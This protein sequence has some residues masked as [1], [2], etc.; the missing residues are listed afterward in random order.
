MSRKDWDIIFIFLTDLQ[1]YIKKRI[2]LLVVYRSNDSMNIGERKKVDL[3][4]SWLLN[5]EANDKIRY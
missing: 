1:S 5:D 3:C 4:N 2:L